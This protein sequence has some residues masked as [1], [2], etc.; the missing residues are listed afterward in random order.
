MMVRVTLG[1]RIFGQKGEVLE[2]V[3]AAQ[4]VVLARVPSAGIDYSHKNDL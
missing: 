3:W 1:F 4:V 2:V